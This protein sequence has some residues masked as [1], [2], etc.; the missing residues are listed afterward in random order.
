LADERKQVPAVTP[1]R[2]KDDAGRRTYLGPL[3]PFTL[4][5]KD[6]HAEPAPK[7]APESDRKDDAC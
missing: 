4:P 1:A 6:S 5:T 2:R 7:P 3:G